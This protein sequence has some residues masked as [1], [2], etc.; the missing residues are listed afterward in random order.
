MKRH[1]TMIALWLAAACASS[2]ASATVMYS[3]TD[4]GMLPGDNSVVPASINNNGQVVG[5]S[6]VSG[7][8]SHAFLYGGGMM[9]DLGTLAGCNSITASGININGQVVGYADSTNN[10][11]QHAFL[12][13]A[14][15]MQDIGH[16]GGNGSQA[17][18]INASGQ[19]VGDSATPGNAGYHGF[20]YS[21]GSM[22]DL[23]TLAQGFGNSIAYSINDAGQIAGGADF[24]QTQ[25]GFHAFLYSGG[26]MLDLGTLG[27][28]Y[29]NAFGINSTGQVIGASL[30]AGDQI[31]HAT[32]Y[33]GGVLHDLG[34]TDPNSSSFAFGISA[35]G[36]AVGFAGVADHGVLFSNGL[37]TDL[38]SL[39]DP[40][41]GWLLGHA[42]SIN[43]SG[44]IVGEGYVPTDNYAFRHAYLLTPVPEPSSAIL[45]GL[46][47][48]AVGGLAMR[49]QW[50]GDQ[51]GVIHHCNRKWKA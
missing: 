28:T 9:H 41:T 16:L 15:V 19:I 6:G 38:N 12:Y 43:D 14:G 46:G 39:I 51:R 23:G 10:T 26:L 48:L 11:G 7:I 22:Q 20:V 32:L 34:T 44:Q 4:L 31:W 37:A 35:S 47:G 21:G 18:A 2:T 8:T 45:L 40:S 24:R 30:L 3:V 25:G 5:A 13:S 29:S 49:K 1:L 27:G 33:S 42:Y 50:T 36:Q 17:L